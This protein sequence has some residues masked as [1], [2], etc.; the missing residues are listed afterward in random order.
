MWPDPCA[1]RHPGP[2]QHHWLEFD[3]VNYQAATWLNHT[4]L[5]IIPGTFIRTAFDIS[6]V[7]T[8]GDNVLAVRIAPPPDPGHTAGEER[9]DR[10]RERRRPGQGRSDFRRHRRL[11]AEVPDSRSPKVENGHVLPRFCT[12]HLQ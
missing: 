11:L 2:D 1:V 5:G 7:V 6:G 10:R 3:G 4:R 8:P 9:R 12:H